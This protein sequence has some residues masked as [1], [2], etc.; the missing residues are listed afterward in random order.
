[1]LPLSRFIVFL[2]CLFTALTL[3]A[4]QI[5]NLYDVAVPVKSQSTADLRLG[6]QEALSTAF[7]RI[8]GNAEVLQNSSIRSAINRA[9]DFTRKFSY[10]KTQED[11]GDEQLWLVIEFE[12]R[13]I[14]QQLR[15]AGLPLWSSNRPTVLVWLV[16]D[17]RDGRRFVGVG[18]D[19]DIVKAITD[20]AQRRGLIV[21]FPVLDLEDMVALSADEL[22]RLN[23]WRAQTAAERYQA[24][25]LLLGR[26][27]KLSN[28][29][30]LGRW[31]FSYDQQQLEFDGEAESLK[32]YTG[33]AIDQVAEL[34]ANQY[35]IAPVKIAEGGVLMRLT[36]IGSFV[37]YARAIAYLESVAAIRHA[38]VVDIQGEEI[39][40]R[41]VADGMLVQL[42]QA[43]ALGKRL[44]SQVGRP[45]QGEYEI[46]LD[47]HW[48]D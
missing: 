16:V 10:R 22:W 1:M 42:Q 48:P 18:R 11:N 41:L 27:S 36:G 21:K 2:S 17:D 6:T 37:D 9:T 40:V 33:S 25:T 19:K 34:L 39:I 29:E 5:D 44:Q 14:D 20:N 46:A 45:Y 30:W 7:I 35:A 13:L 24:D 3:R 15:D 4:E 28:G 26:V 12:Q 47:Y 38:N 31:L 23:A 8:S 32:V 43:F